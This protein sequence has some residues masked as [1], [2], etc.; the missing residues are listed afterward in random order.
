MTKQI[1]IVADS[2][3]VNDSSGS[4]AN[5]AL[6]KNLSAIGYQVTVLHYTQKNIQIPW[7]TCIPIIEKKYTPLY[8]LSRTQRVI[9]RYFKINLAKYLEAIFGFSFTFFNDVNSIKGALKKLDI[10]KFDLILTLSKGA[11]FRPHYAVNKLPILHKKWMA[12]I[13]DPY[14]MSC[15]PKPYQWNEPGHKQK[16]LFFKKVSKN[17]KYSAF[18]S[19]LLQEWMGNYFPNFIKTGIIIPHQNF[20][21]ELISLEVPSYFDSEK[22]NVLHAGNLMKQRHPEGLIRGFKLFLEKNPEAKNDSKLML[23]GNAFYHEDLIKAFAI[24]LPQLYIKLANMPFNE[25][26]WL[27]KQVSVNIILEANSEISPFLPGKFPHCIMANKPIL[28]LGPKN[29]ETKRLLGEDYQYWCEIHDVLAISEILQI[30]Y[31]IWKKNNNALILN[32]S[33]LEVYVGEVYLKEQ[34]E[35]VFGHV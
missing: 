7:V 27:Q 34:L 28:H 16:R 9:Q 17:A 15:Y 33:D 25:V 19:V 14:P 35:K 5:I 3:D 30:L 24:D 1:L 23:L 6:I 29:S 2:I 10:S 8:F 26:H 12:Y 22:F 21:E 13:H 11:S 32:R 4:K 18:P 31:A 20:E